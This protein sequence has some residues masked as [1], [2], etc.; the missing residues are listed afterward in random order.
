MCVHLSEAY[1][2][3]AY[4]AIEYVAGSPQLVL[5]SDLMIAAVLWLLLFPSRAVC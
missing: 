5:A 2:S 4:G 1:Y 3:I